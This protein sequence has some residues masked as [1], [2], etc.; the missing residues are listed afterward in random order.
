MNRIS[1][2]FALTIS[3]LTVASG[4][5]YPSY[6]STS[7][8][9]FASP[10]ALKFGMYG[11][12]N[13]ALLN[14]VRQADFQ[15][16]W[17]DATGGWNDF[18]RWGLFTAI[19]NFGF[20]FIK[21]KLGP[22][23][24]TDYRLSLGFGDRTVGIGIGYGFV[25]GDKAAFDRRNTLT[26]GALVRPNPL[27]SVG[28][29]GTATT[30]GGRSGGVV[31]L[32][33]RPLR[34]ELLTLFADYGIRDDQTL[35]HGNWSYGVAVE[36]LP[37]VRVTG[38]YF[39]VHTF[40]IGLSLSLG[41]A[42]L[43]GQSSFDKDANRSF[44][45]YAIRLGAL[46]RT[47]LSN[48]TRNSKNVEMNLNGRMKYQRFTFFDK[49]NTLRST[50]DA[51]A[52][53]KYDGAVAGIAINTSG[54]SVN[55][56][57]LWELRERLKDFKSTGKKVVIFVDNPSID[58]YDFATVADKIVLDPTGIVMLP[59]YA[60]G[61]TYF[62]GTL[63]ILG[64]GYDEWRFFKYKSAAEVFSRDKMSDADREQRQKY[65]DDVYSV[66]KKDICEGRGF[67]PERFD[68]LVNDEVLFIPS[69]AVKEGLVDTLGR[70]EVAKSVLGQI[71]GG[72]KQFGGTGS[73]AA[74]NLPY[75]NRWSEPPRIAVIYALGVCAMDEG[76]K[77]RTLAKDVE[78]AGEDPKVK[79]IVLRVD[80]PGGDA[81]ASDYVAEAVKKAKKSKPVIVSQG[82]VAGSG[83]YWLSMYADTIVAAP[84]TITGSIGVI[85]GWM[86]NKSFKEKIGITT[87]FVK[88]GAHADLGFGFRLPYIGL[89]VPDRNLTDEERS[90]ME[91]MIKAFYKQFVAKVAD[92]RKTSP[93]KIE[94]IA[95]GHFYSGV[96]GKRLNLVDVLG[97]LED[98][99]RIARQ[100]AGIQ[101]DEPVTIVE[102]PKPGLMDFSGFMPRLIGVRQAIS[103]DPTLQQL[104]FRLQH[105]GQ[106]MP[107]LPLDQVQ[108]DAPNE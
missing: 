33:V 91:T 29:I 25:G 67:S 50:L 90:K 38:R 44:N 59:G 104:K 84:G 23:S 20:G 101:Q 63:E 92:G 82:Y 6:Y 57:M 28:L 83:G 106:P 22:V 7:D 35:K 107:M 81:M 62:K 100:R 105:N 73:V 85:G 86:Y 39:D 96:D 94:E 79:A 26:F 99:I 87:D 75:D 49:S 36:A 66:T 9:S 46:D 52:A 31:D 80:S 16:T 64:I 11:F 14:Y 53:A 42:G 34:N 4:Q 76:I 58:E 18:N 88:A 17:T 102:L 108:P 32:G 1:Y 103:E 47:V 45:T 77:A 21:T 69:D 5:T 10:G 93:E 30:S 19:P 48:F 27:F 78:A 13:P 54:M 2:A 72:K 61:N 12:D 51:I 24:V 37:G 56:E 65:V 8:L 97:G 71:E 60:M 70:W 68:K 98:A 41:N 95:Q 55:R 15:F 3:L 43:S 74:Y 40:A 89:G